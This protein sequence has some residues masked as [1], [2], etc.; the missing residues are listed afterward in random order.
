MPSLEEEVLLAKLNFAPPLLIII[1]HSLSF[2]TFISAQQME[3]SFNY[4]DLPIP[5]LSG[6][7][8]RSYYLRPEYSKVLNSFD[9][10]RTSGNDGLPIGMDFIELSAIRLESF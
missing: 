9:L 8:C 10:N 2:T 6:D 7:W 1:A 3:A 5:T 4:D